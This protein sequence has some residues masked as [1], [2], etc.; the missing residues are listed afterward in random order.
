M[1]TLLVL[2]LV[3]ALGVFVGSKL[4]ALSAAPT[5]SLKSDP[6]AVA[7]RAIAKWDRLEYLPDGPEVSCP[8][9]AIVVA[10]VGQSNA[11]NSVGQR[12]ASTR[13]VYEMYY[14]KCYPA[15]GPLVGSDLYAGSYWP[16]FGDLLIER[17]FAKA[18]ILV[19]MAKGNTSVTQWSNRA[20]L[21][22]YLARRLSAAHPRYVLWHQGEADSQLGAE[23]S[24]HLALV[25]D[26]V[27][28]N[29]P[30]AKV[31]V[32]LASVCSGGIES[33]TIRAAQ[34]A[35]V[36]TVH[37]VFAGPNTDTLRGDEYRYDGCHFNEHGARVVAA[38][39]ADSV[40]A[41]GR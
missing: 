37:G 11:A 22:G 39:W 25:I 17:G 31:L 36:D 18:V 10:T 24:T 38:A 27:R 15:A 21:G 20:G 30:D 28:E 35:A 5:P 23:Y 41:A 13:A 19:G 2:A 26:I 16:I 6:A 34:A 14:G 9:N 12:F 4:D 40:I 33:G 29:A 1:R 7:E 32:A 8:E 3:F